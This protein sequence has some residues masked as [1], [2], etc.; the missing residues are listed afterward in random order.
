MV[1]RI[2]RPRSSW[3]WIVVEIQTDLKKI[4]NRSGK[5]NEKIV[6]PITQ[7]VFAFSNETWEEM[8]LEKDFLG[9]TFLAA[10]QKDFQK[11]VAMI[12]FPPFFA[13]F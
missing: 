11:K 6:L 4:W 5:W 9:F 3:P 1:L 2:S 8:H 13:I 10:A 7:Q 12:D